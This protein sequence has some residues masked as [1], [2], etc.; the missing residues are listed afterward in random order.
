MW[1]TGA[2]LRSDCGQE[3]DVWGGDF[4]TDQFYAALEQLGPQLSKLNLVHVE[5]LDF[6]AVKILS[7]TCT[8]IN[9]LGLYNCGFREPTPAD[10]EVRILSH[11]ELCVR[12]GRKR[13][14]L[15]FKI[16]RPF[17][18]GQSSHGY[19]YREKLFL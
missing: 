6:R 9:T 18:I 13:T 1:A 3:L 2:R 5:E 17:S 15:Q 16:H 4:Y 11:S 8:N 12:K 10:D 7:L 19:Y 14:V